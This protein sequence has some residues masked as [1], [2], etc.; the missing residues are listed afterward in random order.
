[1]INK[2]SQRSGFIHSPLFWVGVV[3]L[4]A[5]GGGLR[6]GLTALET[7]YRKQRIALRLPLTE[8]DASRVA[9]FRLQEFIPNDKFSAAALDTD[10]FAVISFNSTHP[11]DRN[12][13]VICVLT[14]YSDP[15]YSIAHTPE[16]CYRQGGAKIN[17]MES[18][19][20]ETPELGPEH[21]RI[22][23]RL[24]HMVQGDIPQILIYVL[25]SNGRFYHDR[26][27]LR[28]AIGWPGDKY[29]FY[30]K[31]EVVT[32][33]LPTQDKQVAIEMCKRMIREVLP[34]LIANHFPSNEKVKG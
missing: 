6:R 26:E 1:M 23:G 19:E 22:V 9:S 13:N 4:I 15:D 14:Y 27:R 11:A 8:I 21:P 18:I 2:V 25:Y 33:L 31:V 3:I 30:S 29:V 24:I 7:E 32:N 28:F 5:A 20:I 17:G 34:I 16:I 10:D 12:N